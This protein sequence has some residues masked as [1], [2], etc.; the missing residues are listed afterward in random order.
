MR[1]DVPIHTTIEVDTRWP[2]DNEQVVGDVLTVSTTNPFCW[3]HE[4]L[5][6]RGV[7]EALRANN[8][9]VE[10]AQTSSDLH[11]GKPHI[12]GPCITR[13]QDISATTMRQFSD[14]SV[15]RSLSD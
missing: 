6:Q 14:K 13:H 15:K 7:P 3:S 11:H 12:L 8:A 9:P 1:R 4:S 5:A 2:A 10:D